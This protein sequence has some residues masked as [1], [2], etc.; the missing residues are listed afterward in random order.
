[1][2]IGDRKQISGVCYKRYPSRQTYARGYAARIH[3]PSQSRRRCQII[4][5]KCGHNLQQ[6]GKA[7][8]CKWWSITVITEPGSLA[9]C[10]MNNVWASCPFV[11]YY[12][13]NPRLTASLAVPP[14][15]DPSIPSTRMGAISRLSA[16]GYCAA[17]CLC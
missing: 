16:C 11:D 6:W 14:A 4:V 5:S 3:P 1:M 7:L 17:G 15:T 2:G 13:G 10:K 8:R 12:R 9:C